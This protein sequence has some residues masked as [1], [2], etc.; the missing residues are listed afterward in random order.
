MRHKDRPQ[1]AVFRAK[2]RADDCTLHG[3]LL[4]RLLRVH[5]RSARPLVR[6]HTRERTRTRTGRF[7]LLVIEAAVSN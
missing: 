4:R 3:R 7:V 1:H 2:F 5:R 6:E